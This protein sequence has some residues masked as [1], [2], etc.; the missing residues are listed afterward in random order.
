M[1]APDRPDGPGSG[2]AAHR[3]ALLA[4]LVGGAL[5]AGRVFELMGSAV[6][7]DVGPTDLL[8]VGLLW[9]GL[10]VVF[11]AAGAVVG[12]LAAWAVG[13]ESRVDR[14]DRPTPGSIA[15]I[16]IA[17][18][19]GAALRWA[20]ESLVPFR[21]F[22]DAIET[23]TAALQASGPW[24]SVSYGGTGTFLVGVAGPAFQAR[25]DGAL[26]DLFGVSEVGILA[27][28]ALPSALAILAAA[29]LA[30]EVWGARTAVTAAFLVALSAWPIVHGRWGNIVPL[31]PL[32]LAATA[33]FVR[34]GR[35][36]RR[37][38][39][40]AGGLAAGLSLHVYYAAWPFFFCLAAA[41]PAAYGRIPR[42]RGLLAAAAAGALLPILLLESARLNPS[43]WSSGRP[44]AVWLGSPT[45]DRSLPGGETARGILA[46]G[47]A[48]VWR[49]STLLCGAEDPNPRHGL[50]GRPTIPTAVGLLSLVGA[51]TLVRAGRPAAWLVLALAAGGAAAGIA[52]MPQ[53]APNTQRAVLLAFMPLVLAAR[54]LTDLTGSGARRTAALGCVVVALVAVGVA[55][56]LGEWT[57][58]QRV[59]ASF[60]PG[61]VGAGRLIAL[62]PDAP[63]FID[64]ARVGYPTV[65]ETLAWVGRPRPVPRF[66]R[67]A[68]EA[69]APD[70]VRPGTPAWLVTTRE[71]LDLVD[72]S[73][74]RVGRPIAVDGAV[75]PLVLVRLVPAVGVAGPLLGARP[76]GPG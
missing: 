18:V 68:P 27:W 37:R 14:P 41:L 9:L 69:L 21:V 5:V 76:A 30:G 61:E 23:G 17:F 55:P 58:D 34:A 70:L 4:G 44:M 49:Y 72:R 33:A 12:S 63:V 42:R 71:R 48:N 66:P 26:L 28:S 25:F 8:L 6:L 47:A 45:Q 62:L 31:V 29:W 75:S 11:A 73:R 10:A 60:H 50:R 74:F 15:A 32:V 22:M 67:V 57:L 24:W 19:A 51:A 56:F 7:L 38:W 13:R 1:T 35:T 52:S 54:P 59:E 43:T 64:P 40:V 2:P 36:G 16:G 39:A 20:P 46:R 53:G 65:L 3:A